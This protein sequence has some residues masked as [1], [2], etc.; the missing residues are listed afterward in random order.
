M[1]KSDILLLIA[2]WDFLT[3]VGPLVGIIAIAV[4]A[5]PDAD[6]AGAYFGLSVATVVLLAYFGLSTMAGVGLITAKEWGR[7]MAVIHAAT[8]LVLIPFGTVIGA[9]T[10][11]YLTRPSTR[12]YFETARR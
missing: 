11:V 9:L 6:D 10:L 3:A 5:F 1:R 12:E 7:I 8:D 4:F 2:V